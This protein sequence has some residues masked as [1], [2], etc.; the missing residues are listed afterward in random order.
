MKKESQILSNLISE[1]CLVPGLSGHEEEIR[2]LIKNKLK[3][4]NLKFNTDILGNLVC[5]LNGN[6]DLPSVMLFAHM[7]QIGFI[8]KK[9]EDNGLLR[10]EK[11]GGIPEKVLP[12]LSVTIKNNQGKYI[13]GVIGNK[14]HHA[15]LS[16]EKNVVS[17]YKDLVIDCGF[18]SKKE[19]ESKGIMIGSPVT[20]TP[21]F[22]NIGNNRI[23]GTSI[24]DRAGCAIVLEVARELKKIK[25]RPTVHLV[26]SVQE[27]FNLRGVIPIANK[28]LP[29][30]AI[31]LDI[32][33]ASDTPDMSSSGDIALGKGPCMSLYSFH[34]RGTLNGL[35]PHPS[36]VNLI[37]A[38]SKKNNINLQRSANIGLL[39]DSSYVQLLNNGIAC[40]DLGFP[41][42]Y[43]HSPNEVSDLKDL[44]LL[45]KL[46]INS[47]KNINKKFKLL[48]D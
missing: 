14:S 24:D 4:L 31:Q 45:K 21:C 5:T 48:R 25:N 46:L 6:S 11:L 10:I 39:T 35:I 12:A 2:L 32:M 1:L 7:D 42:R 28:L 36:L 37:Y 44:I 13:Q 41:V 38:T 18:I 17:S 40:I 30:I 20:Y 3:K 33:L 29:D 16:E 15:T 27:E 47:I 9:I 8:V 19:A 43:S 26:F 23:A 22:K 34:G